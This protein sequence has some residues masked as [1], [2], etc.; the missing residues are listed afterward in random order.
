MPGTLP[1]ESDFPANVTVAII[2]A[3]K[4]QKPVNILILLHGLGDTHTP[5][6]TFG[7]KLQL[8]ETAC[9]SLRAPADM[10]FDLGGFHWGDN[11][12]FDQNT[13]E[14]EIDTGFKKSTK[15]V[16][17]DVVRKTLVK[18]CGYGLREIVLL[19]FGQG[20][21]VAV[22]VAAEL[23]LGEELGGVVSIGG[24]LPGNSTLPDRASK[25]K[26]TPIVICKGNRMS[27]IN[28]INAQRLKDTFQ[29]LEVVQWKRPGDG[30]PATKE[31]MMPIMQFFARRLRS[32]KGVPEGSIAIG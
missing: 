30:M 23:G 24:P 8:P 25:K 27:A 12:M 21:M 16:L 14:M 29:F 28:E 20:G 11:I 26:Q 31:E 4:S 1:K 22:N 15:L 5:F 9:I 3:P 7:T 18:K 17:E 2:P 10:P 6:A 32:M 13:E 19:G